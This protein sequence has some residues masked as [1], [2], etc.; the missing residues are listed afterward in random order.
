MFLSLLVVGLI[1]L[2]LPL[3]QI[4]LLGGPRTVELHACLSLNAVKFLRAP[5]TVSSIPYF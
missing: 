2:N 1:P 3:N 4:G 5:E